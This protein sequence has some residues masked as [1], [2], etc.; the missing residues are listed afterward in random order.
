MVNEDSKDGNSIVEF[1]KGREL[2]GN[3]LERDYQNEKDVEGES[4][5]R[6]G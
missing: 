1:S 2:R 4:Y 6:I 3:D 5:R